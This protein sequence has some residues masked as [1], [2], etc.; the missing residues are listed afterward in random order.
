MSDD[1]LKFVVSVRR[2]AKVVKGG[3][4]FRFAALVVVG[5]GEKVG[6]GM[7]KDAEAAEASRK[8]TESAKKSMV[9][10]VLSKDGRTILHETKAKF[11]ATQ[12][13]MK[14]AQHGVG[15]IACESARAVFEAVGVKD[16]VAK[17]LGST[18]PYNVVRSVLSALTSFVSP[19][20]L[21]NRLLSEAQNV[22]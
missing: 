12:V 14:P 20:V 9:S 2:T 6:I 3:R 22:A 1:L 8:A 19:S 4:R 17:V 13:Y 18:N 5:D 21:R 16:V 10:V 7:G 15:I 11:C